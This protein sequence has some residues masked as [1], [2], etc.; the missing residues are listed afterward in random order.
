[1]ATYQSSVS[2]A[3][4]VSVAALGYPWILLN[5]ADPPQPAEEQTEFVK[6]TADYVLFQ[7]GND[8]DLAQAALDEEE[9][10]ETPRTSLIA[11]LERII[12]NAES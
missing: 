1:M 10:S 8:A 7:V 11:K 12:R 2:G 5:D 3:V 4:R 6:P 9:A